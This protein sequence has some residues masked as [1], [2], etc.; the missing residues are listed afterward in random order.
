MNK[1]LL[2]SLSLLFAFTISSC[3][4]GKSLQSKIQIV[5]KN[6]TVWHSGMG[7][8]RGMKL[9]IQYELKGNHTLSQPFLTIG[10]KQLPLS[11]AEKENSYSLI[12]S[13][14]ESKEGGH[15]IDFPEGG[16]F[17]KAPFE[18]SK[19]SI[20]LNGKIVEIPLGSFTRKEPKHLIP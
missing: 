11:M 10:E 1:F 3:S 12:A 15:D 13:I 20:H 7:R 19:L 17:E 4:S 8:N 16:L 5:E 6:Y 14:S 9:E 2:L 18:N